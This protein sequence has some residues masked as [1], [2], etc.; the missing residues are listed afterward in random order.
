MKND[1]KKISRIAA[2]ALNIVDAGD[3]ERAEKLYRDVIIQ[4][5]HC[6]HYQ[7][8]DFYHQLAA[9][10]TRAGRLEEALQYHEVGLSVSLKQNNS[11][12]SSIGVGLSRYFLGQQL[13]RMKRHEE[14]LNI[15]EPSIE[16]S[17]IGNRLLPMI[18]AIALWNLNRKEEAR[19][20]AGQVID[21]A[22][23]EGKKQEFSQRFNKEFK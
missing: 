19:I 14:A 7:L 6:D 4:A 18:K 1:F 17:K 3:L 5:E 8:S 10:L 22:P 12:N 9:V 23:T 15:T 16:K 13:L 21:N 2:E 20:I 11:D